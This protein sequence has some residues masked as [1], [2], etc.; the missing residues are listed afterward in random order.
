MKSALE[1]LYQDVIRAHND[2]P[3]CFEKRP[4]AA[5]Q[6]EAYNSLCGDQFTL[7]FDLEQEEELMGL[8]FFGYGCAI[9]KASASILA[10][11]LEGLHKDKAI[12]QCE[13]LLAYLNNAPGAATDLPGPY[14]ALGPARNFPSR[15][16][17]A[18]LAWE[19]LLAY[20]RQHR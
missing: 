10:Q 6:C 9:S 20:L 2:R 18:S 17:C 12:E 3:V 8:S 11:E 5:H 16:S 7:Y 1:L 19:T 14:A 13:A 15:L 4:E